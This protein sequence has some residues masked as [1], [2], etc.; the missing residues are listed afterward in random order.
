M[1]VEKVSSRVADL[2][3]QLAEAE[4]EEQADREAR[5]AAVKP[6]HRYT[7][8]PAKRGMRHD[9]LYDDAVVI[10]ELRRET[11]NRAEAEAAGH[12]GWEVEDG[13]MSYYFNKATGKIIC[14]TGGGS[15]YISENFDSPDDGLAASAFARIS[16]FL[17]DN[18]RGGDV[19]QIVETFQ[20]MRAGVT[21]ARKDGS[22]GGWL[23]LPAEE[24]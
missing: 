16:A 9:R 20:R 4:R 13:G 15:L 19:T 22:V 24:V 23:T 12:Y 6:I 1:R 21:L 14:S 2:R 11:V 18:P 17:A 10:Y 8:K 3:A 7:V 5:K